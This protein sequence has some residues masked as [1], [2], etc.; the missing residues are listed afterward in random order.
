MAF[1]FMNAILDRPL[2]SFVCRLDAVDAGASLF[3]VSAIMKEHGL[4]ALPVDHQGGLVGLVYE[5]AIVDAER[6]G[7]PPTSPAGAFLSPVPPVLRHDQTG[8][9][10]MAALVQS[11]APFVCVM[12]ADGALL[13]VVRPIDLLTP[14]SAPQRPLVVGGLATPFGVYLTS[15]AHRGGVKPWALSATGALLLL[16]HIVVSESVAR[17]SE[18]L[19]T[20]GMLPGHL[21][22]GFFDSM[23]FVGF[24]L[25]IR[26]LPLAGYHAAE[27]MTVHAIEREEVLTPETV[28]RMSRIHPRCGTNVV[29]GLTIFLGVGAQ[30]WAGSA[31]LQTL[32]A[33]ILTM[34]F[35]RP[36]GS[37][38][39]K[40][41][42]TRPPSEKHILSG[43]KA[44]E[45]VLANYAA[46]PVRFPNPW[47]KVWNSGIFYVLAGSIGMTLLLQLIGTIFP[48]LSMLRVEW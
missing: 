12:D 39:Q 15:G 47:V 2:G 25:A 27:H 5:R 16:V 46:R 43:I 11:G 32:L 18:W 22:T 4:T 42:T 45:E 31:E 8:Q 40:W 38:V 3:A 41:F 17:L 6:A 19:T 26:I 36:A 7:L 24:L 44:G 1:S 48:S 9:E 30:N 37:F 29:I 33:L 28:K 20:V 35:F 13:G 14:P 34:M 10:A 23:T 21:Q